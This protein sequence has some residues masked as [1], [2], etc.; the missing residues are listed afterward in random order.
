[1]I[2]LSIIIV[3][4]N[5]KE[6]L[7][8]CLESLVVS[9][10]PSAI[11]SEI[12]VVDNRSTDGSLEM[13]KSF[14]KKYSHKFVSGAEGQSRST[15]VRAS[16][17]RDNS[18]NL[19]IRLIENRVNLGFAKAVNQALRQA[20]GKVIF[21]LNSDTKI[22]KDTL[23]KLLQ[24][25]R[26]VSPAII[27]A[28]MLNPDGSIQAS[29]FNLPTPFRAI[30][31]YWLGEKGSFSK[32]APLGVKPQEVE[33]VSGGAMLISRKVTEK[34]G[35]FDERYFMYFE[36]LDYC[37]RTKKAGFKVWYL[38]EAE[39]IHQHGASGKNLAVPDDQWRRLIPSSKIYHGVFKHWLITQIIRV[40]QILK[41]NVKNE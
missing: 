7:E 24:F 31:E 27:G 32:Y 29:V 37:R 20:Q 8:K 40:G 12:I 38:P 30:Q 41:L 14:I 35:L 11:S 36:D 10:Q 21:L 13:V 26:K 16:L 3:S 5:T 18:R 2:D 15:V 34:I 17:I 6:L 19:T 22:K 25:E 9:L 1:M 39:I 28:A 4:F 23:E 33:A